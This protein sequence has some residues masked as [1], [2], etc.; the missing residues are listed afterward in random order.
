MDI[1]NI[2]RCSLIIMKRNKKKT[3]EAGD[4]LASLEILYPEYKELYGKCVLS[5]TNFYAN[6]KEEK[7]D[8]Y[9]STHDKIKQLVG[10]TH[11]SAG[12]VVCVAELLN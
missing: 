10:P 4:I 11:I 7:S 3:L 8:N 9:K 12:S 2:I 5:V 1:N 6:E